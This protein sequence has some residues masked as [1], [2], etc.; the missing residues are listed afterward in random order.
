MVE[1]SLDLDLIFGSLSSAI[2]RDMLRRVA[3]EELSVTELAKPY[4][5]L[6]FAAISKHLKVLEKAKLV[7]K[8][9]KGKQQMVCLAPA[10]VNNA[11]EYLKEY[12]AIWN[13]RLDRLEHY[14][15]SLPPSSHGER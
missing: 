1:L 13:R 7:L 6:T 15:S 5:A 12:E 3:D 4:K 9:R 14:L 2:R 10:A 11:S 8:R